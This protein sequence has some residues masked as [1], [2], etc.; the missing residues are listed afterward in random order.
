MPSGSGS[1]ADTS[2]YRGVAPATGGSSS[3]GMSPLTAG[4]LGYIAGNS[5]HEDRVRVVQGPV[6]GSSASSAQEVPNPMDSGSASDSPLAPVEAANRS[7]TA[8]RVVVAIFAFGILF[9]ILWLSLRQF[10]W[11]PTSS[12]VPTASTKGRYRL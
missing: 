2:A 8:L 10:L 6:G 4:M 12:P 3:E 9:G 5:R 1:H 11:R 7:F